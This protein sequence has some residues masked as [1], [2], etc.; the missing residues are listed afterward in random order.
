M[1]HPSRPPHDLSYSNPPSSSSEAFRQTPHGY[2]FHLSPSSEVSPSTVQSQPPPPPRAH[3]EH[4]G[5]YGLPWQSSRTSATYSAVRE[6]DLD[7]ESGQRRYL[8]FDNS[9]TLVVTASGRSKF[10]G[11]GAASQQLRE[12]SIPC[13]FDSMVDADVYRARMR[14]SARGSPLPQA[15]LLPISA[16][17]SPSILCFL[18]TQ[19]ARDPIRQAIKKHE[20]TSRPKKKS[21]S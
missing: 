2:P 9:G 11:P 5:T 14:T 4:L 7:D 21:E 13:D 17:L 15:P 19:L 3:H 18:A 16:V 8:P 20:T 10:L 12:V 1:V 6:Q